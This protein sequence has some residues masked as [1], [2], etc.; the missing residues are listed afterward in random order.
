MNYQLEAS[1]LT[2]RDA[3][4]AATARVCGDRAAWRIAARMDDR[5][6]AEE[7]AIFRRALG[8]RLTTRRP[9]RT[10]LTRILHVEVR[11]G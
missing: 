8:I 9:R 10:A 3:P 5:Y 1:R 11:H 4:I 7:R 2:Q 6:T